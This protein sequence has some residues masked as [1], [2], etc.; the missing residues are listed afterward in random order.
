MPTDLDYSMY[1]NL[2]F[3]GVIGLVALF[4]YLRGFKKSL[5]TLIIMIIFYAVFFFTIDAVVENMWNSPVTGAFACLESTI[6]GIGSANTMD[7]ALSISLNEFL[8][9]V[10]TTDKLEKILDNEPFLALV[11]GIVQF[12]LKLG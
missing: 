8:G 12:V 11:T 1:F 10:L 7:E 5:Y 9:D 3:F 4:G 6:P 2:I